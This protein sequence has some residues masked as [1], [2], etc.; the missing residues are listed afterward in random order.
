MTDYVE[1]G[2]HGDAIGHTSPAERGDPGPDRGPDDVR[3][4]C[5]D[6]RP[7][8]DDRV[9]EKIPQQAIGAGSRDG[10]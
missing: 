3:A 9:E 5:R 7:G 6:V 8:P 10:A 1:G 2:E 4:L